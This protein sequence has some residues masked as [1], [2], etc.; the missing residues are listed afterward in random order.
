MSECS[1]HICATLC[2]Y[3]EDSNAWEATLSPQPVSG[4]ELVHRVGALAFGI[5]KLTAL[6]DRVITLGVIL[7][8]CCDNP[9]TILGEPGLAQYTPQTPCSRCTATP[10]CEK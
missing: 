6:G 5:R 9:V 1:V 7:H 10:Y 8:C 3:Q 2:N 4:L